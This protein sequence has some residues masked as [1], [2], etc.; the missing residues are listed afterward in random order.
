MIFN[1]VLCIETKF[2]EMGSENFAVEEESGREEGE[3]RMKFF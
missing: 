2:V 1:D 3:E